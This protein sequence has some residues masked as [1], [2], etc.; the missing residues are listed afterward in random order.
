MKRAKLMLS[1]L[2][3]FAVL[4]TTFAFRANTYSAHYLFTGAIT[5]EGGATGCTTQANGTALSNGT[6][7]IRA[8]L[9]SLT[10]NCPQVYTVGITD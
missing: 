8:S 9:S 3:I 1:A 2:A 5:Q 7:N 4:G 6:A 10:T